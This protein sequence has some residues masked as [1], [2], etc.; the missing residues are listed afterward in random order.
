M[1][2]AATA[3]ML[4]MDLGREVISQRETEG[5]VSFFCAGILVAYRT[6]GGRETPYSS[7][8]RS[9]RAAATAHR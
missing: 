7:G 5:P 1:G 6:A 9:R 8:E 4:P 2:I 3:A